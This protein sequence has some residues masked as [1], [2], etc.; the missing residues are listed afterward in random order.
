MAI[1]G[2][3]L[4][5]LARIAVGSDYL[6]DLLPGLLLL[7]LGLGV[8]GVAVNVAGVEQVDQSEHGLAWGLINTSARIGTA[9][10]LA[11]LVTIAA[12]RTNALGAGGQAADAATGAGFGTGFGSAALLAAVGGLAAFVLFRKSA[13]D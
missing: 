6:F 11:L 3:S 4:L 12:A 13:A 8:V 7:G 1:I 10:G 2:A 9:L 5:L